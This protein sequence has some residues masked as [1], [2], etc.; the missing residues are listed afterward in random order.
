MLYTNE[1]LV[2]LNHI[3]SNLKRGQVQSQIIIDTDEKEGLAYI[4]EKLIAIK[5][6]SNCIA[7]K[8]KL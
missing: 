4:R 2:Q 1:A 6:T 3:N 8:L 5:E 7:D